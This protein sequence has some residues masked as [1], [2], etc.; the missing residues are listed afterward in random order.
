MEEGVKL[1][2]E[3]FTEFRKQKVECIIVN[4]IAMDLQGRI[5]ADGLESEDERIRRFMKIL[6]KKK[7]EWLR[8]INDFIL[9]C[10]SKRTKRIRWKL[11]GL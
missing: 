6:P 9:K 5:M 8:Q 1:Y 3:I 4:G 2:K 10:S 7:L 11:R